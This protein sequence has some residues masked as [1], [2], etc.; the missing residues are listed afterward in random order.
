MWGALEKV[1]P[2]KFATLANAAGAGNVIPAF[3]GL[4]EHGHLDEIAVDGS[5]G[6][7]RICNVICDFV[8]GQ[9]VHRMPTYPHRIGLRTTWEGA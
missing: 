6:T 8:D 2:T 5:V 3:K 7:A 9:Q 1:A 4:Q